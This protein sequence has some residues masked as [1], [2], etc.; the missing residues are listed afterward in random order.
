[1][2]TMKATRHEI[3]KVEW[4]VKIREHRESGLIV[5]QWCEENSIK[6]SQHY[7]W[8]RVIRQESLIQAGTLVV[9]G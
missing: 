4:R 7:Y 6:P 3:L 2:A 8:L 1:M 9:T 5:K